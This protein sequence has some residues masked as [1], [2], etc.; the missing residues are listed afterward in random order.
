M[1][2]RAS[3]YSGDMERFVEHFRSAVVALEQWNGVDHVHL[4]VDREGGRAMARSVRDDEEAVRRSEAGA[5]ELRDRIAQLAGVTTESVQA[6]D[7]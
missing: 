2:A 3:T 7:S 5:D 6:Y 1:W 4:L